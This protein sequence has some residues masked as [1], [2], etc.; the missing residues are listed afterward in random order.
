MLT[1]TATLVSCQARSKY[2]KIYVAGENESYVLKTDANGDTVVN[3]EGDL[4]YIKMRNPDEPHHDTEGNF[5][6]EVLEYPRFIDEGEKIDC[7]YYKITIPSGWECSGT[8]SMQ[9]KN[10]KLGATIDFSNDTDKT[11]DEI[12]EG[13]DTVLKA[14]EEGGAKTEKGTVRI[15]D[16]DCAY[17]TITG[18]NSDLILTTYY[19]RHGDNTY[20]CVCNY[21][22]ENM[23]KIDFA[24]ILN[25]IEFK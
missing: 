18:D 14:A 6:T 17:S 13:V 23:D 24:E 2:G 20:R 25:G 3:E 19:I 1:V 8:V 16:M 15:L 10:E 11:Y 4:I 22:K 5:I 9:M 7:K 21:T 12:M